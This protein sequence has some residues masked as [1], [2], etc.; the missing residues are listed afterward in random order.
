M[1]VQAYLQIEN[2]IVTNN[3]MWDGDTNNW[4]PPINTTMLVQETTPALVW[5]W[6][7]NSDPQEWEL[8]EFVGGGQIGFTWDGTIL[9]TNELKPKPVIQPIVNGTIQSA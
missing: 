2:N 6:N 9:T 3:V 4:Q 5:K 8:I 7:F 1:I